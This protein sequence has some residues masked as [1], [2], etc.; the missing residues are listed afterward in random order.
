MRPMVEFARA[1][2]FY[3]SL[4]ALNDI[5]TSL[6]P[7]V[8]GLLGP[9]GAG[10]TTFLRLA[11]GQLAPSQGE[12]KV[13]GMP[14]WSNPRIYHRLGVC[15]DV[16]ACWRGQSGL[17]FVSGLLRL[18]GFARDEANRKA[19]RALE[20]VDLLD[21]RNRPSATYSRGMR[22]RLKLAQA[23]AHDPDVL[24]LDE[25]LSGMDPVNRRRVIDL[26]RRL[27]REGKTIVVSSHVLPEIEAMT[28]KI[29]LIHGGRL[30]A[31]GDVREIRALLDAHPHAVSLRSPDARGLARAIAV[32]PHVLSIAFGAEGRW[33][34]VETARP[35]EFYGAAQ[36]LAERFNI[37]E[38]FAPDEDLASVFRY[39]VRK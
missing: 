13:L 32:W 30:L 15:P 5:T 11:S 35:E 39:L 36:A 7:G 4:M 33:L 21:V 29:L 2:R 20:S 34:T 31:E 19:L 22:Q 24:L 18:S 28:R 26:V 38:I 16:D 6:H 10:K 3:G 1:S 8:T 9:N 37:E 12:V 27:G 23:V 25:P 17:Q 14:A